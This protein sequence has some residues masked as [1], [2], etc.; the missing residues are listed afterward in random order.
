MMSVR[1]YFEFLV[2]EYGSICRSI[3][4]NEKLKAVAIGGC[5]SK[6]GKMTVKPFISVHRVDAKGKFPILCT[7]SFGFLEDCIASIEFMYC[8]KRPTIL[9]CDSTHLVILE[10]SDNEL[11]VL[12]TIN[13]HES[14]I[15][16]NFY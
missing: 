10:F 13:L 6:V 7:K 5:A 16:F 1:N 15:T 2:E 9:A 3:S 12:N 8:V 4:V 11:T 14:K